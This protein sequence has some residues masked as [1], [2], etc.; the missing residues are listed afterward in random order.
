M[1]ENQNI[2]P[3]DQLMIDHGYLYISLYESTGDQFF[4]QLASSASM[5]ESCSVIYNVL[6][7]TKIAVPIEELTTEEKLQLYQEAKQISPALSSKDHLKGVCKAIHVLSSLVN[8]N[9]RA[10]IDRVKVFIKEHPIKA[11]NTI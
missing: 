6:I 9:D 1:S 3:F 7:R 4:Y 10:A 2:R 8:Y 11:V 5:L